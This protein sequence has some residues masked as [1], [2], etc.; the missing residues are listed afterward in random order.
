MPASGLLFLETVQRRPW[1]NT[2]GTILGAPPIL[3]CF[4][5]IGM[6]IGGTEVVLTHS[7]MNELLGDAAQLEYGSAEDCRA[8]GNYVGDLLAK[9]RY[10]WVSRR[11]AIYSSLECLR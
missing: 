11:E 5:G 9:R 10:R 8:L 4:S 6:F 7:Q 1:V 2:N 3:V